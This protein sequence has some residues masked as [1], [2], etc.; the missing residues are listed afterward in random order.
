MLAR[1]LAQQEP[2][3]KPRTSRKPPGS[4]SGG[5]PPSSRQGSS[6]RPKGPGSRAMLQQKGSGTPSAGG[7]GQCPLRKLLGPA[8]PVIFNAKGHLQVGK[9]TCMPLRWQGRVGTAVSF[10]VLP[11]VQWREGMGQAGAGMHASDPCL[12][13]CMYPQAYAPPLCCIRH[14]LI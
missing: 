6:A 13:P 7:G 10:F 8:A 11:W 2:Q 3:G 4:G 5:K 1:A 12:R 9:E 14:H